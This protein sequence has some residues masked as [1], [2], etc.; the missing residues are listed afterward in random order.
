MIWY[1][2]SILQ[3]LSQKKKRVYYKHVISCFMILYKAIPIHQSHSQF[4]QG[5]PKAHYKMLYPSYTNVLVYWDCKRNFVY[6][7]IETKNLGANFFSSTVET[8]S[9]YE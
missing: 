9:R 3:T 6:F 4:Y 2:L 7:N 1:K 8:L 5:R